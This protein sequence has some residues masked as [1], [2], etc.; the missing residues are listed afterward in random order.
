MAYEIVM[1]GRDFGRKRLAF[2]EGRRR[3]GNGTFP[4][5]GKG[6]DWREWEDSEAGDGN[7]NC[8][9]RDERMR[10]AMSSSVN[11]VGIKGSLPRDLALH[12]M[13]GGERMPASIRTQV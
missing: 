10:A 8:V 6:R 9:R 3:H 1:E 4:R 5:G 13:G 11:P 7:W 2:S 12:R